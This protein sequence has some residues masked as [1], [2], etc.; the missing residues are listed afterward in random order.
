MFLLLWQIGEILYHCIDTF[1]MQYA[2]ECANVLIN[3]V[4]KHNEKEFISVEQCL[5]ENEG[6]ER[7]TVTVIIV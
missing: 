2:C 3:A 1:T 4:T 6:R 7:E 5:A